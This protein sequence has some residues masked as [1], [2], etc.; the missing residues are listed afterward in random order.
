LGPADLQAS[1]ITPGEPVSS[2]L[3]STSSTLR[4]QGTLGVVSAC[5]VALFL[6]YGRIVTVSLLAP[7]A[8]SVSALS[9]TGLALGGVVA[10]VR[11]RRF[12]E[13]LRAR[14]IAGWLAAFG[15]AAP[16]SSLM[17]MEHVPVDQTISW[18]G[19]LTI[20]VASVLLAV[21][22]VLA[23]VLGVA[24]LLPYERVVHRMWASV[25]VGGAIGA[26][27]AVASLSLLPPNVVPLVVGGIACWVALLLAADADTSMRGP[28]IAAVLV[29]ALSILAIT[30]NVFRFYH[31]K[32]W[33][34][35]Y[36]EDLTWNATSRVAVFPPAAGTPA[37]RTLP[38]A[39]GADGYADARVPEFKWLDVDGGDWTPML[40]F[41][42]DLEHVRFLLDSVV[43]AAHR[44]RS[45]ARVLVVGVGGGRD[46]LAARA[47]ER[48]TVLGIEP[49]PAMR[50]M[51][52]ERFAHYSGQPYSLEGVQ[53]LIGSP[54][55]LL[56]R[57][58]DRFDVIKL[59]APTRGGL[60][61]F[62]PPEEYLYT[63]EAFREYHRRLSP[64]GVLS[65]TRYFA[66]Q[67]PFEV[68]RVL[69]TMRDAWAAEG[70]A[71]PSRHVVVLQQELSATV[72]ALRAPI[73]PAE[74]DAIAGMASATGMN[75]LLDPRRA[76]AGTDDW[77]A[78]V[79]ADARD[80]DAGRFD[81]RPTT[82]DRPFFTHVLR[83]P[84]GPIA[85]D[86]FG[87]LRREQ[88]AFALLSLLGLVGIVLAAACVGA[89]ATAKERPPAALLLYFAATGYGVMALVIPA[90]E[91]LGVLLAS[92][93]SAVVVAVCALGLA[94]AGGS[95]VSARLAGR[96]A[97][98][99]A[100]AL[101][102]G[103]AACIVALVLWRLGGALAG[104][105][106]VLSSLLAIALLAPL[107]ALLG[108][109]LPLGVAAARQQ[110]PAFLAAATATHATGAA[111]AVALLV[112]LAMRIGMS[113]VVASGAVAYA[114]A[115]AC[116]AWCGRRPNA[117]PGG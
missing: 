107:G 41:D 24:A 13:P 31:V 48:S 60:L 51:V 61:P 117:A 26:L 94:G 25:I 33:N 115:A 86:P 49:N 55:T 95:L 22:F 30:Q 7:F 17:M 106:L 96:G 37:T 112:P 72:L 79:G 70:A 83:S 39:R 69:A 20:T 77:T 73:A 15:F 80:L 21:P 38:L 101:A 2:G 59:G 97:H 84:T 27:I 87:V 50:S 65:V 85:G 16:F 23:G 88:A 76:S 36:A 43:Y 78:L 10:L 82:D 42:G 6:V 103:G 75:L 35:Q 58:T 110:G 116:D 108:M 52:E 74:L 66:P 99:S 4:D 98:G 93:V 9:V 100:I 104:V 89:V 12:E 3:R 11:R 46:L 81:Y 92:N 28:G 54:R 63:R 1:R 67:H 8:R 90:I 91:R 47:A 114:V 57:L 111:A 56:P 62:L 68:L 53:I 113:G 18:H 14:R 19:L 40:R 32:A 71:D 109:V 105:S 45:G 44:L 5:A 34:S 64:T 29:G 102:L